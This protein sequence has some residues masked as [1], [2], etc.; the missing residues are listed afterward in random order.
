MDFETCHKIQKAADFIRAAATKQNFSLAFSGGKDSVVLE[1]LCSQAGVKVQPFHN[2]TTIDPAGTISFCQKHG[3]DIVRND[4]SFLD[5]VEKK[6]LPSMFR[7]F[8]CAELKEKYYSPYVFVGVRRDE[9][10]KRAKCYS[11][12]ESIRYYSKTVFS[13]MFYPLLDFTDKDI[14]AIVFEEHLDCH[15]LYYDNCGIFHV[16]RRLGCLG[17]P[18]KGDRGR[19]DW[20]NNPKLLLQVLRRLVLFHQR[21]GR[22]DIDAALNLVYNVFYSNHGHEKFVKRFRGLFPD[23]PW[24]LIQ[25]E[26]DIS[27]DMVL[28]KLPKPKF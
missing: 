22:T 5:L 1:W 23:N 7:R 14:E 24:F 3:C 12:Y 4:L 16:E 6:G 26:F 9:S 19:Q 2:V 15:P 28:D 25:D 20:K 10:I 17:C 8:C 21:L 27:R 18:L 13:N 11:E